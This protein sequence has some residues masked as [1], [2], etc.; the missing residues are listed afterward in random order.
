[1]KGSSK[2]KV[3]HPTQKPLA[4]CERLI[5]SSSAPNDLVLDL[6]CGAGYVCL[7]AKTFGR[8]F[9]G[10]EIERKWV[11]LARERLKR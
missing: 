11:E 3:G 9:V 2:E 6:F 1:L 5:L 8:R 4:V 10:V 7:A